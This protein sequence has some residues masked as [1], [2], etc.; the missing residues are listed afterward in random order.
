MGDGEGYI[1]REKQNLGTLERM[2][3]RFMLREKNVENRTR[4]QTFGVG[5]FGRG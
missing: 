3:G 4:S 1:L 5:E 2:N